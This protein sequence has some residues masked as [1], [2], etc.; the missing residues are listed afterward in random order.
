MTADKRAL[1]EEIYERNKGRIYKLCLG[2][3]GDHDVAKDL[4]QDTFV[5]VWNHLDKFRND[6]AVSTWIYRIAVNTCLGY[7][8]TAKNKP[9]EALNDYIIETKQEEKIDTDIKVQL[10]YKSISKLEEN[11]RLIITMV[12]DDV[13]YGDIASISGITEGNLRVRIHRIKLKLTEIYKRT[14]QEMET[15]F[16]KN[17]N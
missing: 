6:A 11:D 17:N 5:K 2:Y 16:L 3:A 9:S 10:L 1:F 8:R 13:A 15:A 7:L 14:E 12:L 4:M